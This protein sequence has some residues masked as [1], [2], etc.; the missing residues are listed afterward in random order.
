AI[1]EMDTQGHV[2]DFP[3]QPTADIAAAPDGDV[4][5][6][7]SLTHHLIRVGADG[8]ARVI[9][10]QELSNASI[11]QVK[12]A[13]DGSVWFYDARGGR[14]GHILADGSLSLRALPFQKTNAELAVGAGNAVWLYVGVLGQA[15]YLPPNGAPKT[16]TPKG[17]AASVSISTAW[18]TVGGDGNLYFSVGRNIVRIT[19]QGEQSQHELPTLNA[20]VQMVAADPTGTVWFSETPDPIHGAQWAIIGKFVA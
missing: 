8:S 20:K 2:T 10:P 12:P 13:A 6:T 4:W 18:F 17:T 7:D 14:V 5:L 19:Q 1:S 9:A 16:I 15:I 11:T 3:Y